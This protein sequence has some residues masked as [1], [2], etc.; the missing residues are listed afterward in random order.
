MSAILI[1][2]TPIPLTDDH[3]FDLCQ[4]NQNLDLEFTSAGEMVYP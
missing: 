1:N 4:S 3:F 2:L